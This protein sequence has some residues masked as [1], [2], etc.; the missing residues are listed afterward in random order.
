MLIVCP[1]C[2]REN[3][4]ETRYCRGCGRL[5]VEPP[6]PP[7]D[8]KQAP[9]Y[10]GQMGLVGQWESDEPGDLAGARIIIRA[11]PADPTSGGDTGAERVGEYALE[12]RTITIGRGQSCDVV[13]EGDSL[14]SRRHAILRCEADHYTIADLGSSNGTLLNDFEVR[15]A[16]PLSHGD[17]IL[18]GQ[19]ELL[20]LLDQPR[21]IA[22][23]EPQSA[24]EDT[25]EQAAVQIE[26]LA[27]DEASAEFAAQ[28]SAQ[29]EAE[30]ESQARPTGA[31]AIA[32]A[33]ATAKHASV[34]RLSSELAASASRMAAP[35]QDSVELDAIR[36]RLVEA[37]EALTRQAG[38]QAALAER[39][40][41]TLVETR[42]RLTDLI[43]DL[44]GDDAPGDSPTHQ[45][46]PS[47]L[48]LVKRIAEEPDDQERLRTLAS[49]AG[50]LAQALRSQGPTE[51]QWTY[52]RAQTIR[53]LE[54][55]RFRLEERP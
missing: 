17:R 29:S 27:D 39:R 36:T 30:S 1:M 22:T 34:A 31:P 8:V 35:Q 52:E 50:E 25:E 48:E 47:L 19:H 46:Q 9:R 54:D 4:E 33:G 15:E 20:F 45:P 49:R 32:V 53:I 2:K 40:R 23:Q 11:Y 21:A 18:I 43:A 42:E 3:A 26:R 13:F 38:V 44:R 10:E 28:P 5:L 37:S 55:V 24:S 51:G 41:A 7:L 6:P 14:T 16:T 12:G